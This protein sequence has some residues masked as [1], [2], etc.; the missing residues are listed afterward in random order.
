MMNLTIQTL[1]RLQWEA[2]ASRL[3]MYDGDGAFGPG[4]IY[5]TDPVYRPDGRRWAHMPD[6]KT[7]GRR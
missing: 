3:A 2:Y 6:A 4:A 1:L 7:P 5:P